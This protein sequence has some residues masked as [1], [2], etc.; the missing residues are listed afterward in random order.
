MNIKTAFLIF[1]LCSAFLVYGST[2]EFGD[3]SDRQQEAQFVV[4]RHRVEAVKE[5]M[6][7]KYTANNLTLSLKIN[8]FAQ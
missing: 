2:A 5:E 6:I 3:F 1:P 8:H 4:K 7:G